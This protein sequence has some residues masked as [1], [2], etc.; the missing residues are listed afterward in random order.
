MV[1]LFANSWFLKHPA[2]NLLNVSTLFSLF[3]LFLVSTSFLT[4]TAAPT[5]NQRPDALT[6]HL[7]AV[8]W[9][10]EGKVCA[11][12]ECCNSWHQ[13]GVVSPAGATERSAGGHS[14]RRLRPAD[15]SWTILQLKLPNKTT[16]LICSL[17]AF[18]SASLALFLSGV[19]YILQHNSSGWNSP[20][21][22]DL[23]TTGMSSLSRS[24][25]SHFLC[26]SLI[27]RVTVCVSLRG[28]IEADAWREWLA[29]LCFQWIYN[30][31]IQPLLHSLSSPP[32][33]LSL[34][35]SPSL[36]SCLS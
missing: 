21:L 19:T 14:I 33:P 25:R 18:T 5:S 6:D 34:S 2:L 36:S 8:F 13:R 20:V 11:D 10:L 24:L 7:K 29:K 16:H 32:P 31:L 4:M 26:M 28:L 3:K 12:G 23:S 1:N 30:L 9:G 15:C 27:L 35:L 22:T 17:T